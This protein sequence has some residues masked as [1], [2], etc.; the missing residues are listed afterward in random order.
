MAEIVISEEIRQADDVI[1]V[2]EYIQRKKR[3]RW[4]VADR[5]LKKAPL[6]AAQIMQDEFPGYTE[7]DFIHDVTRKRR[8]GKKRKGKS[9][10]KRQG[11]YPF[12]MRHLAN[13][14]LTKDPE[15]LRK[16][17]EMRNRMFNPIELVF[18]LNGES[19]TVSFPSTTSVSFV[20]G[21]AKIKFQ[22]WEEL[23][24]ILNEKLKYSHVQ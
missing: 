24:E 18:S 7:E 19:K 1:S 20:Q 23:D 11:R 5:M 13:Y 12:M 8:K 3:R 6:F 22:S 15:H 16:A 17:Q 4:R 14:Q 2:D 9:P 10:L 21:L